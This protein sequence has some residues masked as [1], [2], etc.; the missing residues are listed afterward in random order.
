MKGTRTRLVTF[1]LLSASVGYGADVGAAPAAATRSRVEAP[2]ANWRFGVVR[3][4]KP[5]DR[6]VRL[7]MSLHNRG[8]PSTEEV[9]LHVLAPPPEG[10]KTGDGGK[11]PG[12]SDRP[13]KG[14]AA[15]PDFDEQPVAD[16]TRSTRNQRTAVVDTVIALP[17]D[18]ADERD[19]RL[20]LVVA[21][22]VTDMMPIVRGLPVEK[23][24]ERRAFQK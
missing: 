1:L 13:G 10:S 7:Y 9:K 22:S 5:G 2:I 19:F 12:S 11:E 23:A 4:T 3:V 16:L 18:L 17:K 6:G 8:K 14:S 15:A 24:P 21:G 20:F